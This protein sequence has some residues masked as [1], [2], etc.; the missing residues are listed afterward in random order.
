MNI[1]AACCDKPYRDP[2]ACTA[3]VYTVG[4]VDKFKEFV[5]EKAILVAGFAIGVGVFQVSLVS[6]DFHIERK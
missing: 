1:P 2:V 6:E 4:C 3:P 5:N